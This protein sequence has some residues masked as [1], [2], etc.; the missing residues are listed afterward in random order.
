VVTPTD[1]AVTHRALAGVDIGIVSAY[2]A[3]VF[4]IG[5]ISPAKNGPQK[6]VPGGPQRRM[7]CNW[8]IAFRFQYLD[9][10]M[11]QSSK[12]MHSDCDNFVPVQCDTK[13]LGG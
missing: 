8:T 4:S 7:V 1:D 13:G 5:F 12:Q 2:F 3:T 10:H 11:M 9:T 6:L